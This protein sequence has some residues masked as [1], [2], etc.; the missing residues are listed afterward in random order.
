[1]LKLALLCL[2]AL[3]AVPNMAAKP[4]TVDQLEHWV[5]ANRGK[6]DAKI[7]QRLFD[8][9]L[10]ERLGATKLAAL[11][12]ALPGPQSRRA[13]VALSD[14]AEFLDP[15]N[16][17]IPD[18]PSPNLE[19]QR[20]IIAQTVDYVAKT[21]H[22]LPNLFAT[23]D[24]IRFEDSPAMQI[25]G[26]HAVSGTFIP[27]QPLHPVSRSSATVQY[28]DG[29]EVVQAAAAKSDASFQGLTTSGEFGT[30]LAT[31]L[32]DAAKSKL[33][34][35]HWEQ[36]A[37]GPEAV[38]RYAVPK[39]N[40][41]YQVEF[42]CVEN[43]VFRQFSGYHG[44]ITVDPAHG[45]V[46]RLTLMADLMKADPI[47]KA[48]IMV[49][50]GP[51]ELG[52]QTY[53]CP[54]KSVSIFLAPVQQVLERRTPD[55]TPGVFTAGP[56]TAQPVD[57]QTR[58]P[59][60]LML[61][62][63]V[64][65][66]YHLFRADARI[67]TAD[68]SLPTV[69]PPVAEPTAQTASVPAPIQQDALAEENHSLA[70]PAETNAAAPG[71]AAV[72]SPGPTA[73]PAPPEMGVEKTVSLPDTPAAPAPTP[74]GSNFTLRVST[75]LVDV[76]VA[77][78]D[79]SGHPV[80]DLKPE[81]FEIYDNGQK[82]SVRFF[83]HAAAS[84][85]ISA[86]ASP[87]SEDAPERPVYSNRPIAA[88]DAQHPSAATAEGTS[89]ILLVDARSLDFADLNLARRQMLK[90]FTEL[91][92]TERVGLYVHVAEGFKVI[93]E[94]TRDH[95]ALTSA[96][97][98]WMPGARDLAHA[99]EEEQRNRQQ[100][101]DVHNP[102]DMQNVNGN[103]AGGGATP[104]PTMTDPKLK[105]E[106]DAPGGQAL[107]LLVAVAAHLAGIPGHKNL[108]WIASDNVLADWTD[109]AAGSDKGHNGFASFAL[110]AQEALNDA[111]V[112]VYPLDASQLETNAIDPSLQNPNVEL[113]E[114][115]KE[116]T[117]AASLGD[118]AP[119]H[120][121]GRTTAGMQQDLHPIQ[122]AIQQMAQATGGRI[123]RRSDNMVTNLDSVIQDGRAAYLLSF[124]PDSAPD[125]Q[126]HQ[127]IVKVSKHRGV[128]L[129]YRTGYL[130]AK[131]PA[132]LK[133][134]FQQAIWQPLDATEIALSAHHAAASGG[135]AL[136]LQIA[137]TDISLAQQGDRWTDKLDIFLVERDDS[138][139][140]AR[141]KGQTL[142]LRLKPP[143]YQ[144]ILRDGIPFD[145]LIDGKQ[146]TGTL[147][148]IVV[149]ENSGRIGSLTLPTPARN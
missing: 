66:Q 72:S 111:H 70:I 108:V 91:P 143:T 40:S 144:K 46:L 86:N 132:T 82:Q 57:S 7:A 128:T 84:G 3:I 97:R 121:P 139:I 44:E 17:D 141:L 138:G 48:D 54:A 61:N 12:A 27:Y 35:S 133:E 34:W 135:A 92:P 126:Y 60:Q 101:D 102:S 140:H 83:S 117:P 123:F 4:V 52:Q 147:R 149:D 104:P 148:V 99:Q 98:Q 55:R 29:Q 10:T 21:M 13:L 129:R 67:L 1:M 19:T 106:G 15:P 31:V 30:T 134:R 42:C 73:A 79:K 87:P 96:L 11:E 114:A 75:R 28:R 113:E 90:F 14:Q 18:V 119:G 49:E 93:V 16:A 76:G 32:G 136:T 41:H 63:V 53:I 25:S 112:S 109:R 62:E 127:L 36:G 23:R 77:A 9:D 110:R 81:D 118:N 50:Y 33:V 85:E 64:F 120:R 115:V 100:F 94:E 107:T 80:T 88:G 5:I 142:V 124:A 116:M 39:A 47:A 89:T 125:D 24:T 20:R 71:A 38:F 26:D 95:S 51:V 68:N 43:R 103:A 22:Q 65:D 8:L 78:Y 58:A 56:D 2:L 145:E 59:L 69:N 130:Y 6:P 105:S 37:A 146:D 74:S 45:T 137:A 131:E 122:V